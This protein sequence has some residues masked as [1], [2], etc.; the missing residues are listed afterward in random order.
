M[1][2]V[3]FAFLFIYT[4][5]Y[6]NTVYLYAHRVDIKERDHIISPLICR[7]MAIL[8]LPRTQL[9]KGSTSLNRDLRWTEKHNLIGNSGD[10]KQITFKWI[11]TS[12]GLSK[13]TLR[14]LSSSV[15]NGSTSVYL[16][17]QANSSFIKSPTS[18][19][20]WIFMFREAVFSLLDWPHLINVQLAKRHINN[21]IASFWTSRTK[22]DLRN[23]SKQW[24]GSWTR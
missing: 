11:V 24:D 4:F 22:R 19:Q 17:D 18:C 20:V 8:L 13:Y 5:A 3:W 6:C 9:I 10:I 12:E 21:K 14:V 1:Q 16:F 7:Y 2:L 23:L 15:T